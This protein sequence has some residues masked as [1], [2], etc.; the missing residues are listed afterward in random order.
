MHHVMHRL[1]SEYNPPI[2]FVNLQG[3]PDQQIV[4]MDLKMM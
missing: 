3:K 1:T 2:Y 4:E